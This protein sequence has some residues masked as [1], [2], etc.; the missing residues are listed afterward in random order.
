MTDQDV[1]GLHYYRAIPKRVSEISDADPVTTEIIRNSLN[2][3]ANQVMQ[4][5]IR[6]AFS[7][8]I[9][10]MMDFAVAFYDPK[11]QMMAQAAGGLP[12]FMGTLSFCVEASVNAVGG[13]SKLDPGDI[14]IFNEPYGTGS[15]AQDVAIIM[16]VFN[17][18]Q[19]IGYVANKAH[20]LDIGAK[21]P[22]CTDTVDVFQE[23]MILPGV[24]LFR[25]GER[26]E[27]LFRIM[28]AN[29]RMPQALEGDLNAQVSCARLGAELLE[30]LLT[31][32]GEETF[33]GCVERMYDHGERMMRSFIETLPDGRY[34]GTGHID[35][36]GI[37]DLPI[38]FDVVVDIHG[39][40]VRLDFSQSPPAQAGPINCPL[41]STISASRVAIAMLA[42]FNEPPNEGHFRVIEVLTR[43]N[44]MYHP[45]HPQPC[46]SY[47]KS[48]AAAVDAVFRGFAQS[49]N[50]LVPS[51][52]NGDTCVVLLWGNSKA[53][54]DDWIF[55]C[56]LPSGQGAHDQ[57]DGPILY[58]APV[59]FA[60]L[61]PMEIDEVKAPVIYERC[62]IMPDTGGPG[63]Y[64]GGSGWQRHF[65]LRKDGNMVSWVDRTKVPSWGQQGGLS[66]T[67]NRMTVVDPDGQ[68]QF[69]GKATNIKVHAGS[70]IIIEVGGG[71]GYGRPE[72]RD[73]EC[74]RKDLREG[75][76]SEDHA[77]KYYSHAF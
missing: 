44:S 76:I 40:A 22:Y 67:L 55:G 59:A 47:G 29:S 19:L 69:Y 62:E 54:Q 2:S 3:A 71:G 13:P 74:V 30:R 1:Q 51:G 41:P 63:R 14:L 35:N 65:R 33:W 5:L 73:P 68:R 45:V 11:F 7:P 53:G 20:N 12:V 34:V 38:T 15:H 4:G 72:E 32:Y 52:S 16:P 46:F 25:H 48:T 60:K 24:K 17:Q 8:V 10:E 26:D 43:P 21:D 31:Q 50:G 23:G 58:T 64:R 56:P 36:N 37:D 6:T 42:G 27:T 9:Y 57:G 39:S 49:V 77:R 18:N 75:Y 66:G 70:L 61:I 28:R